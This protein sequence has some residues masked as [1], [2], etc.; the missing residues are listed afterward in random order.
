MDINRIIA[1]V[2]TAVVVYLLKSVLKFGVKLFFM[3]LV[4][5]AVVYFVFPEIMP[6][7]DSFLP[8]SFI[9]L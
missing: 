5:A 2:V 1:F 8:N 6:L 9:G 4:G 7:L 3:V